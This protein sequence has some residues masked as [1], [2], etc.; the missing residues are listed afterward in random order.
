M[1]SVA[2]DNAVC[3]RQFGFDLRRAACEKLTT[4]EHLKSTLTL[5]IV[6]HIILCLSKETSSASITS[7]IQ[8]KLHCKS[9][10]QQ[11]TDDLEAQTADHDMRTLIAALVCVRGVSEGAA[12]SLENQGNEVAC[13][14]R[15][16]N[17]FGRDPS[18][19]ETI[20]DDDAGEDKV[21]S[22]GEEDGA[23]CYTD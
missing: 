2:S 9:N 10:K 21:D 17:G 1:K 20:V 4:K 15:E 18:V 19:L 6:P 7:N 14:E 22:C 3:F 11:Q 5:P 8:L 16:R 23:N 13:H 12:D